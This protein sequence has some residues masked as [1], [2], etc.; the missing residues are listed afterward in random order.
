MNLTEYLKLCTRL[1]KYC[2]K[3]RAQ[4]TLKESDTLLSG[5]ESCLYEE[6]EWGEIS[7]DCKRVERKLIPGY[8]KELAV[9][10]CLGTLIDDIMCGGIGCPQNIKAQLVWRLKNI[11]APCAELSRACITVLNGLKKEGEPTEEEKNNTVMKCRAR[12]RNMSAYQEA[13]KNG[14][15]SNFKWNRAIGGPLYQW[16]LDVG[17]AEEKNNRVSWHIEDGTFINSQGKPITKASLS[18]SKSANFSKL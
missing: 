15:V 13:E 9:F 4:P 12:I 10:E 16:L 8:K 14:L 11:Y 1:E 7:D 17:I 3:V 18:A 5:F 6:Q 2:A